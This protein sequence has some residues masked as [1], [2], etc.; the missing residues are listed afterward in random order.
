[1]YF[2]GSFPY[3]D[4]RLGLIVRRKIYLYVFMCGAQANTMLEPSTDLLFP[5]AFDHVKVVWSSNKKLSAWGQSRCLLYS[6]A[7][8]SKIDIFLKKLPLSPINLLMVGKKMICCDWFWYMASCIVWCLV[9]PSPLN[10]NRHCL[11]FSKKY[12]KTTWW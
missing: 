7:D 8:G 5:S 9:V 12:T 2:A 11:T 4:S 3:K 6:K 1:M 10:L